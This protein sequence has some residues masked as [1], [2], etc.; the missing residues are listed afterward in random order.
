MTHWLETYARTNTSPRTFRDYEGIVRRYLGP[1]LG[2]VTL[3]SLGPDH[4]LGMYGQLRAQGLSERTLLHVHVLLKEALRHAVRWR[5]LIV[6]PSDTV[7]FYADS[8]SVS[9]IY[10]RSKPFWRG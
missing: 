1:M 5:Q 3:R 7:G 10:S 6:N 8:Q 9:E 4:I 2:A